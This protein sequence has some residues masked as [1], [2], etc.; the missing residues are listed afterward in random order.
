MPILMMSWIGIDV[1]GPHA[2]SSGKTVSAT[3][4]AIVNVVPT[5]YT[6]RL[7][8][9]IASEHILILRDDS[10]RFSTVL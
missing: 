9:G 7:A 4:V 10:C 3:P 8:Q 6:N 1:G 5:A 2:V